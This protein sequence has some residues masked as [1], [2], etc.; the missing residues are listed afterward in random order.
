MSYEA[1][2]DL[3]NKAP[4]KESLEIITLILNRIENVLKNPNDPMFRTFNKSDPVI[5][6]FIL[7]SSLGTFCLR[8]MGCLE[9]PEY[10]F[11]PQNC[12]L[13]L[14]TELRDMLLVWKESVNVEASGTQVSSL[15]INK[16]KPL[17]VIKP[18]VLP[19]LSAKYTHPFF[20]RIEMI[21]HSCL[22]YADENILERAKNLIPVATLEYKAQNR[23]REF[24]RHIKINKLNMS[25]ILIQD[26]L[27]LELLEWFKKSFFTWVSSPLCD[28]CNRETKFSHYTHEKSYLQ[29]TNRVELHRCA[30]CHQ[31]TPFA[32]YE[33]LNILLETRRGRCGEWANVFTLFCRSMGWDARIVFDETDHVWTEVYSIGQERWLHCDSCENMCDQPLIYEC[34]WKKQISYVIAYSNEEVQDVTWRYTSNFKETLKR[35][36]ACKE[37]EIIRVLE[38]LR[39]RR[40]VKFSETRRKYLTRR[41]LMELVQ[42]LTEKKPGIEDEKGRQ[43][44]DISWRVS[45]GEIEEPPKGFVWKI[46]PA[47]YLSMHRATVRYSSSNDC[48]ELVSGNELKD[49]KE[50]W[51]SGCYFHQNI[52]R[53]VEDDWKQVYLARNENSSEQGTITWKF[54]FPANSSKKLKRV[55][56]RFCCAMYADACIK[57]QLGCDGRV[58][59]INTDASVYKTDNFA[60][61]TELWVKATLSGGQGDIAWQHAQLFRQPLESD[62]F[63]FAIAFTF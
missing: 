22:R 39:Q 16:L 49:S 32:R 19:V 38:D 12:N 57:A 2:V 29:Y 7:Q 17:S 30:F 6:R 53:K 15:M 9:Q 10:Y 33:D 37:D 48:Y 36:T 43:S 56:V 63:P 60:G 44:G 46:D 21:F 28:F 24:Q 18:I 26:M 59:N 11:L 45:R 35:R 52:F 31:F 58:E 27:I 61:Q 54:R 20:A 3:L 25:E 13:S 14:L 50:G 55:A 51:A 34:G 1:L 47:A 23:L 41:N 5:T 40:Q 4:I 8:F 42:F 62:K